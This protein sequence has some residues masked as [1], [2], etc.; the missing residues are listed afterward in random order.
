MSTDLD[1]VRGLQA[2]APDAFGEMYRLYGDKI[3]RFLVRLT[4]NQLLAEDLFQETWLAAARRAHLLRE[5]TAILRWLYTIAR[6][7]YRNE[8]RDR[9]MD[10][11]RREQVR[12]SSVQPRSADE[13]MTAHLEAASAIA[14]MD[15]LPEAFREVLVLCGCEG[16][17]SAEAAVVLGISPEAV[18]KRL[19]RARAELGVVL[20]RNRHKKGDRP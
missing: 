11:R 6:N 7:K 15:R 1:V 4:G 10:A 17:D 2:G 9:V 19:S 12:L 5:D 18:R 13:A 14:A 8:R 3:W 16:L 20:E